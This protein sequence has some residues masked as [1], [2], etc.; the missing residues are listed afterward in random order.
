MKIRIGLRDI[1]EREA[2][3]IRFLLHE[4]ETEISPANENCD[5]EI[6]KSLSKNTNS[7]Q[8][9][10]KSETASGSKHVYEPKLIEDHVVEL[11]SHNI[12]FCNK[13]LEEVLEPTVSF[14]Y[15]FFTRLPIQ[16]NIIPPTLRS[17]LL[18]INKG[19]YDFQHHNLM[20]LLRN[21][22]LMA[23]KLLGVSLKRMNPPKLIV[24]HDIDTWKGLQNANRLQSIENDLGIQST[25]FVASEEYHIPKVIAKDLSGNSNIGS[26]DTR[27][28]GKLI[29]IRE[30]S[31]IVERLRRSRLELENR[32]DVPIKRFRSPL[33][34]FSANILSALKEAGY[35]S[36]YSLPS[37]EPVHPSTMKGFGLESFQTF[38]ISKVVEIPLTL[39]QDHQLLNIIGL[40]PVQ[41]TRH[42]L[43]QAKFIRAY[44]GDI[45]LLVHPDYEF[46]K[47]LTAYK[48]LLLALSEL[49]DD[50]I[51]YISSF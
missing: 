15:N 34:Q 41:A 6:G 40:T 44:D 39:Y 25:W 22:L 35:D 13:K 47:D 30:R 7:L 33:L 21:N 5:V 28:D 3:A 14:T 45:V 18:R 42:W 38:E 2:S 26:H 46:S 36:D 24:T 8:V 43:E 11:P 37:W 31:K 32:F 12:E 17:R 50:E 48:R 16:Y 23:F 10:I 1:T 9:V 20:E 4:Y 51:S 27:H 49:V 29:H 19:D